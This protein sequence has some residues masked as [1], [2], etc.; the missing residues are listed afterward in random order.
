VTYASILA[1]NDE[2]A[3]L[4]HEQDQDARTEETDSSRGNDDLQLQQRETDK[5]LNTISAK[6]PIA[7]N[8][9]DG[10][11]TELS[12]K[13]ALR[14]AETDDTQL[15]KGT[16]SYQ[17]S[18]AGPAASSSYESTSTSSYNSHYESLNPAVSARRGPPTLPKPRNRAIYKELV[19]S[20]SATPNG[21]LELLSAKSVTPSTSVTDL[22][23]IAC[24]PQHLNGSPSD[25]KYAPVVAARTSTLQRSSKARASNNSSMNTSTLPLKMVSVALNAATQDSRALYMTIKRNHNNSTE[26]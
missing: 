23:S 21:P 15:P 16:E 19:N 26:C 12:T 4:I 6:R 14:R 3:N 2:K 11:Q 22:S 13:L 7:G 20:Q 9:Y 18:G 8:I 5:F 10:F 1:K 24:T 25:D 17:K